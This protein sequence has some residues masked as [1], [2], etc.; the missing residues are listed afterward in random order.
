MQKRLERREM[1]QTGVP[2]W[3]IWRKMSQNMRM[4][5]GKYQFVSGIIA[6]LNTVRGLV[7][8]YV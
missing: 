4:Y 2:G 3:T 8:F 7:T 6:R 1:F 5:Y